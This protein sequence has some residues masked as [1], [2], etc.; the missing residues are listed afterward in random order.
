MSLMIDLQSGE[1]KHCFV[2]LKPIAPPDQTHF[3]NNIL[4]Y[5]KVIQFLPLI[6]AQEPFSYPRKTNSPESFHSNYYQEFYKQVTT[7][8]S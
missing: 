6:L 2:E 3:S 1:V 7:S 5:F 8:K 4:L